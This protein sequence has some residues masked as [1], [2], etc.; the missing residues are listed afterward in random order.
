LRAGRTT[1]NA[2]SARKKNSISRRLFFDGHQALAVAKGFAM[3]CSTYGHRILA[4]AILP[5]HVHLVIQEGR[6][7]PGRIVGDF[8]RKASDAL[9]N[10]KLHPLA[11]FVDET[12]AIPMCWARRGW[13]VF[14]DEPEDVYRAVEYVERNPEK[15]GKRRQRWPFV[16]PG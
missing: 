6:K 15:E 4:C 5:E 9:L 10:A 16:V 7:E 11:H 13:N 2:G 3:A 1:I 8:K 14:L 12:G